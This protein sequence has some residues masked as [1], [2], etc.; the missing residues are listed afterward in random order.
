MSRLTFRHL[1]TFISILLMPVTLVFA[2]DTSAA[3]ALPPAYQMT[4]FQH[5]PQHWNNCGPATLT[6]GLTYY[7]I[8]ADQDPAAT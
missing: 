3:V 1:L 4:G 8:A 6:M 7:G 5:I 2:Q